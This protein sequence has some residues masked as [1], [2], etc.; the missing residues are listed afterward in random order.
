VK[1]SLEDIRLREIEATWEL[2]ESRKEAIRALAAEAALACGQSIALLSLIDRN[3]QWIKAQVGL[4]K[5]RLARSA[6]ICERT[7]MKPGIFEIQDLSLSEDFRGNSLVTASPF[8]RFYAGAPLLSSLGMP[9][10][11]LCVLGSEPAILSEQ[12]R[13]HL[14]DISQR[15]MAELQPSR[16]GQRRERLLPTR[17]SVSEILKLAAHKA[18]GKPEGRP[19]FFINRVVLNELFCD[20]YAAVMEL[21]KIFVRFTAEGAA[22]LTID[23]EAG[24]DGLVTVAV[25]SE[26]SSARKLHLRA[27]PAL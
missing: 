2:G 10:G 23:T 19:K 12:Q 26:G 22:S 25:S 1:E 13:F 8:L 18:F 3:Y 21:G 24:R 16:D 14:L 11:A 6:G 5:I 9:L 17:S 4:P 7:M 20:E 27:Y 15:V